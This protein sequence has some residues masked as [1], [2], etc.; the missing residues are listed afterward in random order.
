MAAGAVVTGAVLASA[1]LHASWNA[2]AHRVPEPLAAMSLIGIGISAL[3]VPLLLTVPA[4]A[5]SSWPYLGTSLT[6]HVAYVVLLARSYRLGD[7]GQVYPIARGISPLV[8]TLIAAAFLG[9]RLSPATLAGVLVVC[10]GLAVLV[11]RGAFD[12]SRDTRAVV[13]AG[14]TG[15]S[16]SAYTVVDGAGVR[17]A[18]GELGYAVWLLAGVGL[19]MA[20]TAWPVTRRGLGA[21]LAGRWWLAP[22]GGVLCWS[23]YALVLWAQA[24]GALGP[25]AALRETSVVV[26]AVIGTVAFGER[27]GRRRILA[28]VLVAAG[29]VLINA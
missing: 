27:F 21:L 1:V 25:V 20:L 17:A 6:L 14:A 28:T 16:I 2:L 15:L 23:S 5:P 19:G 9:E 13:A 3:S 11:G 22:V 18:G 24:R 10:A 4:P 12:R 29:I 26:A 8:V 7:F